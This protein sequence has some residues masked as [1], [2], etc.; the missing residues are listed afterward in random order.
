MRVVFF[1]IV[2]LSCL[3]PWCPHGE[4]VPDKTG[5]YLLKSGDL[6]ITDREFS[7]E[8]ELKRAAYPY[9]IQKNPNEYN[10]LVIE[11]VDQLSEELVLRRAARDRG[12]YVT[13]QELKAN[14]EAFRQDYPEDS[15]EKLLVE[16]A[17]SHRFWRHR[18]KLS[19]LF[20]RLIDKDLRQNIE[21]TPREM[22]ACY[23]DLKNSTEEMPDEAELVNKIR[24]EKAETAY[25]GWIENL[26]KIYPVSINRVKI[27]RY[28]KTMKA[29]KGD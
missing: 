21:I 25:P 2:V 24:M 20:D 1:L 3:I 15:F 8:L 12:I 26:E 29:D 14:E 23:N 18:L 19:L 10:T 28:L 7:E 11:L 16:N 5:T 6:V 27:D 9:G 13:D 17:V 4:D 22:I